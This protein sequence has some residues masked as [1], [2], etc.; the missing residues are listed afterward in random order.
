MKD[1]LFLFQFD[2]DTEM[3]PAFNIKS[4]RKIMKSK[5]GKNYHRKWKYFGSIS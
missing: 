5:F 3:F 2:G 1:K 4:A